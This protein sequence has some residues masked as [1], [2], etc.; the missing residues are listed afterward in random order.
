[1]KLGLPL[2]G[3]AGVIAGAGVIFYLQQRNH[4]AEDVAKLHNIAS[5][6]NDIVFPKKVYCDSPGGYAMV[7]ISGTLTGPGVRYTQQLLFSE[8]LSAGKPLRGFLSRSDCPADDITDGWSV[9]V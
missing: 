6:S 8:L 1:M 7:S 2:L 3:W 9:A 4:V 5:H